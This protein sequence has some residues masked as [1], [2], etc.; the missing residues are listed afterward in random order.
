MRAVTVDRRQHDLTVARSLLPR[1]VSATPL[2]A[3]RDENPDG[4]LRRATARSRYRIRSPVRRQPAE[5]VAGEMAASLA[6]RAVAARAHP[7]RGCRCTAADLVDHRKTRRGV[8]C[9]LRRP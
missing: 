2:H 1:D 5:G 6:A 3:G 7:W 8:R 9:A 4:G